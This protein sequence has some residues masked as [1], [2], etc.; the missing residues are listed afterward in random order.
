MKNKL[1]RLGVM[2]LLLC[3]SSAF[4][5]QISVD[6]PDQ[7]QRV[8][9]IGQTSG[10]PEGFYFSLRYDPPDGSAYYNWWV[11]SPNTP[12]F[13]NGYTDVGTAAPV[14]MQSYTGAWWDMVSTNIPAV[15]AFAQYGSGPW[16]IKSFN[17]YVTGPQLY[18]TQADWGA[19]V[20]DWA[21]VQET[22][23]R[24]D[25]V[26][27]D[28][29][30]FIKRGTERSVPIHFYPTLAA[31]PFGETLRVYDSNV[32]TASKVSFS[33]DTTMGRMS[34]PPSELDKSYALQYAPNLSAVYVSGLF[35]SNT[36][37]DI[38]LVLDRFTVEANGTRRHAWDVRNF[39]VWSSNLTPGSVTIS[40]GQGTSLLAE[41][42][43]A[44]GYTE[45]LDANGNPVPNSGLWIDYDS[46]KVSVSYM[47]FPI[48]PQTLIHVSDLRAGSISP[49]QTSYTLGVSGVGRGTSTVTFGYW[50]P[51]PSNLDGL[52][53]DYHGTVVTVQ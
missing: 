50:V 36:A 28:P 6:Q 53:R 21:P 14:I 40:L 46:T 20:P 49:Y 37:R 22:V 32:N 23:Q 25:N 47:G 17:N 5:Y 19:P 15:L 12:R 30:Y 31:T 33:I 7:S 41:T 26:E 24:P 35:N 34:L 3:C 45:K 27:M 11:S 1:I 16:V 9:P 48:A 39:T 52:C 2:V 29:G 42:Y 18:I 43:P 4:G 13:E 38:P 8:F 51:D 44:L 10:V